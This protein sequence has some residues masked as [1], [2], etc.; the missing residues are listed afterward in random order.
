MEILH[1]GEG[2]LLAVWG[3]IQVVMVTG[4]VGI[5]PPL[6]FHGLNATAVLQGHCTNKSPCPV[7][8]LQSTNEPVN[9]L[10]YS[11][12]WLLPSMASPCSR[13][14]QCLQSP[15]YQTQECSVP[16]TPVPSPAFSPTLFPYAVCSGH[17]CLPAVSKMQHPHPG[18][19]T[20]TY[21]IP[22]AW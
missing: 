16:L 3:S 17:G 18:L 2:V 5:C 15:A 10:G 11:A 22:S 4:R 21:A 19:S 9:V 6:Y 7:S 1:A 13:G 12:P 8:I 20:F 14:S